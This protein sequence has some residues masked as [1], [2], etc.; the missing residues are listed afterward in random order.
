LISIVGI[1]DQQ[2]G[3]DIVGGHRDFAIDNPSLCPGDTL[4]N[5]LLSEGMIKLPKRNC[6]ERRP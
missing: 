2:Y 1:L 4:Y 6:T 3:I 5:I